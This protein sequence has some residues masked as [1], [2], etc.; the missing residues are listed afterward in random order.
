MKLTQKTQ[1]KLIIN[2]GVLF[3]PFRKSMVND[4]SS[5]SLVKTV[6]CKGKSL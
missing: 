6:Y 2:T 5:D 1:E 4:T 3:D